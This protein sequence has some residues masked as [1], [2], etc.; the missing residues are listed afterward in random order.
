MDLPRGILEAEIFIARRHLSGR[1]K[2][3]FLVTAG[4]A[5]AV[6]A[7]IVFLSVA[8]GFQADLTQRVLGL[9]SHIVIIPTTGPT[10]TDPDLVLEQ[11]KNVGGLSAAG[12][13]VSLFSQGLVS[14][15]G[16]VKSVQMRGVRLKDELVVSPTLKQIQEEVFEDFAG[17]TVIL[18][19]GVANWLDVAAGDTVTVTLPSKVI[20]RCQ[21]R[22]VF[23]S[24]V[25]QYD[26]SF[27]YLPLSTL[28][29]FLGKTGEASEI[30]VRLTEPFLADSAAEKIKESVPD[31]DAITWRQLNR[32]L[33]EGLVL[34]KRVFSLVLSLM[35]VIAGFGCANVIGMHIQQRRHDIAILSTMGLALPRIQRVF[36]LQGC[37][38]GGAGATIGLLLGLVVTWLL[39]IF[40]LPLPGDIYPI[41]TIPVQ[42]R[43]TDVLLAVLGTL[44]I[45]ALSSYVPA[46]RISGTAPVEV[47][48][49]G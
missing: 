22:A 46:R 7:I 9:T 14:A 19:K 31:V 39:S 2:Q 43:A 33:F 23:D 5:L 47:L 40:G 10:F 25:A 29:E 27:I 48:R 45:S 42:V 49:H 6:A 12:T 11:L 44:G 8:N 3:N 4:I 17:N 37:L 24:G 15:N 38:V 16:L 30:R 34:E 1:W 28:Q 32:T 20:Q 36:L 13:S 35:L 41:D 18:G 21:V 26:N